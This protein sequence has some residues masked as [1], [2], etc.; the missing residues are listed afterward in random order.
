MRNRCVEVSLLDAPPAVEVVAAQADVGAGAGEDTLPATAVT[1]HAA[2]LLSMVRAAGLTGPR[3]AMAAV[4]V[5]SALVARRSRGRGNDSAGNGPAPRA[6][7]RWAE[8][9]AASRSRCMFSDGDDDAED[10]GV[11]MRC[12]PLAYPRSSPGVGSAAEVKLVKA[13]LSTFMGGDL[14]LA[15]EK[16]FFDA[17]VVDAVVPFSC[18]EMVEDSVTRQVLREVKVIEIVLA[19]TSTEVLASADRCLLSWVL[20]AGGGGQSSSTPAVAPPFTDLKPDPDD[21]TLLRPAGELASTSRVSRTLLAQAA[22]LVARKASSADRHL[23]AISSIR[24]ADSTPRVSSGFGR[25]ALVVTVG[26]AVRVMI[27]ALFDSPGWGAV[28]AMLAEMESDANVGSGAEGTRGSEVSSLQQV[29]ALACSRWSPADPRENP[30]LFGSFRRLFHGSPMWDPCML[31]LGMM[32]VFLVRRLPLVL[33]ERAEVAEARSRLSSGRRGEAGLAW[34]GLSW[35]ICQGGRDSSM[36]GGGGRGDAGWSDTRL[37]RSLLGPFLW[38]LLNAVDVLVERLACREV[39]ELATSGEDG[40]KFPDKLLGGVRSVIEARD[41]L[42]T[43]LVA[44]PSSREEGPCADV[45]SSEGLRGELLFAWD[46]FLVSWRW[47]QQ[48]LE[49]L[50]TTLHASRTLGN[51]ANGSSAFATLD[52]VGARVNAAVLQHAGGAAPTR[53]SLW[54]HGPRAA[55]PSSAAGAVAL[56]RL[57]RLADEFRILPPASSVSADSGVVSLG[58]LLREAHPSLSASRDTRGEL[59]H[60]LCTLQWVCSNEQVEN[61]VG[62]PSYPPVLSNNEGDGGVYLTERLPTALENTLKALRARFA[63]AHKGTRLGRGD[64]RDDGLE[65]HQDD[66]EFGER[67]DDFD[68]EATEAV[69]NATLLVIAGDASARSGDDGVSTGERV[70]HGGGVMQDWAAVQLSPLMEHWIAVEE[71]EILAA[72]AR[73][74]VA[75]ANPGC[76]RKLVGVS[77]KSRLMARLSRLRSAILATPSLSPAVARPH[78]TLLWAL[79]DSSSWPDVFAPLLKRLLPVAT[80]S[81]GR[82]LWENVVGAPEAFSLQLAPPEMVDDSGAGHKDSMSK[83]SSDKRLAGPVEL[84][85]LARSSFLLRLSSTAVFSGGVVPG[86]KRN[87]VDLTLMNASARLGQFRSAMRRVRDLAYGG[88]GGDD[89][90]GGA[91]KPLVQLTWA[92]FCRTLGAFDDAARATGVLEPPT[93][94]TAL[95]AG[96]ADNVLCSSPSWGTVEGPLRRALESCADQRLG[97]QTDS[98][99]LPAAMHLLIAMEGV[100]GQ[101][102]EGPTTRVEASAGL[103]MALLGCLKLILL[104][105]SSPV[106]PG[107]E[108]ALKR[109]LLAE[110]LDGYRGELT[111]RRW[112][113]RLEGGGDVSPEVSCCF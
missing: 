36:V 24:M 99:V 75:A 61:A 93:F 77:S 64:W 26:E 107:L 60:A 113:L 97:A 84:L 65:H 103:G 57:G 94:A 59:L 71:C 68:T 67:F 80:A 81:F 32:D 53:D 63:G 42:S 52:A 105:P 110:R 39:A 28:L 1:E 33:A 56:A 101:G 109:D 112:S 21:A 76:E 95:L 47:L 96:G 30:D 54:K 83:A 106:D 91:L 35:L 11:W 41:T 6:L 58:S 5:H 40:E 2:D 104:L 15:S 111:V 92:R 70:S 31:L 29:A 34:L 79:D 8:L 73:L 49:V 69:A 88:A 46:P 4:T 62:V 100:L 7:L 19:T 18:R 82:R 66:L 90:A 89:E 86:G 14:S 9:V 20:D 38:P 48:G 45:G 51:R 87:V 25:R 44:A 85:T 98:L 102:A 50:R 55:A 10:G 22:V 17:D 16:S 13:I 43:L 23:R 12:L 78:Q 37:A 74:D 27:A 3:E 108:P 72:L